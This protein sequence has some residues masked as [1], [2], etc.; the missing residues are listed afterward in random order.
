MPTQSLKQSKRV[1]TNLY[2]WEETTSLRS[3][4][5]HFLKCATMFLNDNAI[6]SVL[7]YVRVKK[8]TVDALNAVYKNYDN[9]K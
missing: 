5:S 9:A 8:N 7:R 6:A 1:Q 2:L 3:I 4:F